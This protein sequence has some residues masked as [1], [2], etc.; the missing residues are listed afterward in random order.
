MLIVG[1]GSTLTIVR[2]AEEWE[3]ED[4]KVDERLY[5]VEI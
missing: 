3:E 5:I 4:V 1:D 2:S